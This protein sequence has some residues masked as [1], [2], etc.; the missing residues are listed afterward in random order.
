MTHSP[1][2]DTTWVRE[3]QYWGYFPSNFAFLGLA[4]ELDGQVLRAEIDYLALA[5]WLR[6]MQVSPFVPLPL[7]SVCG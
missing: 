7:R 4:P 5:N 3:V 6:A 2:P 1:F